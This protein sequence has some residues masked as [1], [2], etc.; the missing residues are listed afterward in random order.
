MFLFALCLFCLTNSGF[1]TSEGIYDYLIA[2]QFVETGQISFEQPQ[3]GTWATAPN[4]R[5][6]D[7]HEFGNVLLLLPTAV[8]NHAFVRI[9]T[10]SGVG[11]EKVGRAW[12]FVLPFQGSLYAALTLLFLYLMLV[13]EFGLT[14]RQ[15]FAGCLFLATCTYFWTYSRTLFDGLLA[16]LLLTVALR[17]LLRFRRE[18]RTIDA[19]LAFGSLGFAVDSRV[20]MA[21][22]T[23]AGL[24]FV[25]LFCTGGKPRG[26]TAAVVMLTP[27]A[28]WQLYYNR[29]RTGNPFVGPIQLDPVNTLDG[30]L[31]TGLTG[32]LFSPGKSIF[33]YAPL[34]L[35]SV[36]MFPAFW[37]KYRPAAAFILVV[38]V[39]WL[40]VHSKI[41]NWH[42]GW[43]W[44]PKYFVTVLPVQAIPALVFGPTL[45]RSRWGRA[46]IV[47]TA[48]AGF[49]LAL[50][51]LV[52][53]YHYRQELTF[54]A[55]GRRDEFMVW[56]ISHG[57]AIDMIIGA[58]NN[59]GVVI[60][61][62]EPA[63][64][65][66]ASDL[67]NYISNRINMWWYTLLQVGFP[68]PVVLTVVGLLLA[69]LFL[70]TIRLC[71]D[72]VAT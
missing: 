8:A 18:G 71:R 29:L 44:G 53:N 31:G 2:K 67:N 13:E 68:R 59:G 26:L 40:L 42:G 37:R 28:A 22:P 43:G 64:V 14:G 39:A 65:P 49:V 55:G 11:P 6:Y 51:S 3:K 45:W 36:A 57:Q 32:H 20:S 70:T 9:L 30:S 52:G 10:S 25:A 19:L 15:A 69:G 34:L 50:S 66:L 7:A 5:T 38:G 23:A 60:G 12:Q 56:S 62:R 46:A 54:P 21:I 33:V 47:T 41:R 16:G 1:E 48:A 58:L 63:S 4:G 24:G 61:T 27:F 72:T 17:Y 35:L